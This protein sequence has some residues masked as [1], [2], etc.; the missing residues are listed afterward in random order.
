[1][2]S[3]RIQSTS[4]HHIFLR[5]V[6]LSVSHACV[7]VWKSQCPLRPFRPEYCTHFFSL[8]CVTGWVPRPFVTLVRF[9]FIGCC[10]FRGSYVTLSYVNFGFVWLVSFILIWVV[11]IWISLNYVSLTC[12]TDNFD[13][14]F[15]AFGIGL[16]ASVEPICAGKQIALTEARTRV[17]SWVCVIFSCY[18]LLETKKFVFGGI[19]LSCFVSRLQER[20]SPHRNSGTCILRARKLQHTTEGW[21]PPVTRCSYQV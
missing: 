12:E 9:H 16:S 7:G 13:S 3:R 4:C 14:Y 18:L 1:M 15:A 20:P 11:F 8:S 10:E 19:P 21:L 2:L 5:S 17:N 6:L